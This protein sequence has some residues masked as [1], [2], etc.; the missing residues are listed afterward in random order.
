[1]K[2]PVKAASVAN[3]SLGAAASRTIDG[4][5]C[6]TGDRVLLKTQSAGAENGIYTVNSDFSLTRAP[7]ADTAADVEGAAVFVTHGS[8]NA[9]KGFTCTTDVP[10]T[11]GTT[12]LTWTGFTAAPGDKVARLD[13][14][15]AWERH[16]Q[17]FKDYL[18]EVGHHLIR[19]KGDLAATHHSRSGPNNR[20]G[21]TPDDL[22]PNVDRAA[23]DSGTVIG[24]V[25]FNPYATFTTAASGAQSMPFSGGQLNVTPLPSDFPASG[26]II[27]GNG[28]GQFFKLAYTGKDT[29]G[30][31]HK[32]TGVASGGTGTVPDGALVSYVDGG[33]W[34]N[35]P[36]AL[37]ARMVEA[38]SLNGGVLKS[39]MQWE[40]VVTRMGG[41]T[42][43]YGPIVRDDGSFEYTGRA[44]SVYLSAAQPISTGNEYRVNFD[45]S[46]YDD[47]G[48][49]DLA[50]NH[51]FKPQYVGLYQLGASLRFTSSLG[52]NH[53]VA[54]WVYKNG[55]VAKVLAANTDGST[56]DLATWGG[57]VVLE[58]N[59]TTDYF[60]LFV[61]QD[62][63]S[64]VSL[65]NDG[66]YTYFQGRY[67]GRRAAP[68]VT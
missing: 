12:A 43:Y 31:P 65:S 63:G 8:T 47:A 58:A 7:D 38:A 26:E 20:I 57:S 5:A 60:E 30:S 45:T 44:F 29:S 25:S 48:W 22:D 62:S 53:R 21:T 1:M 64:T 28:S 23:T 37:Q 11:L 36:T 59:G 46:E 35:K 67:L 3:E 18:E 2:A 40:F 19:E 61:R 17:T 4:Y 6:A 51:R 39:G 41:S 49:F 52:S 66:R 15:N 34:V 13:Q 50:T 68:Q 33:D 9:S 56:D 54:V 14:S 24:V 27:V 16:P 55:S 10:I 32:L 42:K